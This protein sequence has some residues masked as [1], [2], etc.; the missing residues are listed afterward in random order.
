MFADYI[1]PGIHHFLIYDPLLHRAFFKEVIIGL[2]QS[3]HYP[4]L[5]YRFAEEE[6]STTLIAAK[7]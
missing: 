4:E 3:D 5:P 1:P 2:N 7:K 6:I